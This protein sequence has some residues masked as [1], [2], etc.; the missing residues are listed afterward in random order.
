MA[1][2]TRFFPQQKDRIGKHSE[3]E[4]GFTVLT[5]KH[6]SI[7]QL[8]TYGSD[9]REFPGKTS[10]SIQIDESAARELLSIL[11]RAFPGL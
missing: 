2:I 4:C 7:L 3:V 5:G 9:A 10:Q 6:G 11:R 8:D 1:R